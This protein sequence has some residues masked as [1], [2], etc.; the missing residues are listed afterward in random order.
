MLWRLAAFG[1]H[2]FT[3]LGA[4][5]GFQA[6]IEAAAHRWEAAFSWLGLALIVDG[7]DGPVARWA[8]VNDRLPRF[9]GERLDLII[10]YLTYVVV[11]VFI[12]YEAGLVPAAFA[13]MAAALILLTSLVHFI[14]RQSKTED[15]FFVG[16]PALWNVVA[17]YLMIFSIPAGA[18]FALLLALALLTFV[19]LKWIHPIRVERLRPITLAVIAAWG[20]AVVI[21]L[22][23]GFPGSL[24]VQ[25]TIAAATL[26]L[27]AVG[28]MRSFRA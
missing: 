22:S 25:A 15:G 4:I 27:L 17:L 1:V 16:F 9:S 18:G 19:P 5:F 14:D 28:L 2:A 13:P 8:R 12:I 11:P 6:L 20:A 26:Y 10:D 24:A 21:T 3:A 23:V 7:V